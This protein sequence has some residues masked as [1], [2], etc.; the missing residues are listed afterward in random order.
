MKTTIVA[1]C[2]AGLVSGVAVATVEH[3][4]K[5]AAVIPSAPLSYSGVLI[6]T[7]GIPVGGPNDVTVSIFDNANASGTPCDSPGA[8]TAFTQGRFRVPLTAACQA[9]LL[10]QANSFVQVQ[11]T[12]PSGLQTIP[13]SGPL[14]QIGMV[15]YAASAPASGVIGTDPTDSTTTD[16]QTMMNNLESQIAANNTALTTLQAQVASGRFVA[17]ING[18][19]YSV[20]ATKFV[21]ATTSGGPNSNGTYNGSQVG[22]YDGAKSICVTAASSTSAHMCNAEEMVRSTAVG[23]TS[24]TEGWISTGD[25]SEWNGD[26]EQDCLGWTLGASNTIGTTW[27]GST[28]SNSDCNVTLAVLCCD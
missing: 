4:K 6:D 19:P 20:G 10:S 1:A 28:S 16:L 12:L 21:G 7:N 17:T 2:V 13:P 9:V 18:K 27:V 25:V 14:P 3:V 26:G 11:V 15:P 23:V 8:G 24:A 22:G 5:P